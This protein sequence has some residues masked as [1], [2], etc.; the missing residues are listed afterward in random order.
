MVTVESM[1]QTAGNVTTEWR[2]FIS[3]MPRGSERLAHA[4]C[5]HWEI[6]NRLHWCL[7]MTFGEDRCR[8]RTDRAPHNLNSVR[9]I[10]MNLL[11]LSLIKKASPK[12]RLHACLDPAYLAQ[13]LGASA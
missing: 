1:R 11:R 13:V 4:T 12:K 7:D 6:E 10:A 8:T 3:S 2:H 9:K 5:S